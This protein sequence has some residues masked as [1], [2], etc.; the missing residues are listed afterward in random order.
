MSDSKALVY[1]APSALA[2]AE[3][4]DSKQIAKD[5]NRT[6]SILV[7]RAPL[8]LKENNS[9]ARKI[10]SSKIYLSVRFNLFLTS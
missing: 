10:F 1:S 3:Y 6:I 2:N 4:L 8:S 9:T 5:V 7:L